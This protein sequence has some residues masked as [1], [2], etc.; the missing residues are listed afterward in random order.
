M[1]ATVIP[2]LNFAVINYCAGLANI[3][4]IC[5]S[6]RRTAINHESGEYADI[7][8]AAHELGH[9]SVFYMYIMT[10]CPGL[11]AFA[12]AEFSCSFS[13]SCFRLDLFVSLCVCQYNS[14][15]W[16][17]FHENFWNGMALR[18]Q[19]TTNIFLGVI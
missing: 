2:L 5:D 9:K 16:I 1:I 14:K 8:T 15:L 17:N 3:G 19:D 10:N 12:F 7:Q 18:R 4:G 6:K 11:L 13:W